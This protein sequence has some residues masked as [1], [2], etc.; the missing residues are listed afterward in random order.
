MCMIYIYIYMYVNMQICVY[1]HIHIYIYVDLCICALGVMHGFVHKLALF[2]VVMQLHPQ[3]F[4]SMAEYKTYLV[5]CMDVTECHRGRVQYVLGV[6][7]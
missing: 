5:W 6:V 2:G 7:H 1:I 3:L 4:S